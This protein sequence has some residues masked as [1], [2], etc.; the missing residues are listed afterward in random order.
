MV[1]EIPDLSENISLDVLCPHQTR[2]PLHFYSH[3]V[4]VI[5]YVRE[6]ILPIQKLLETVITVI[7]FSLDY[8]LMISCTK[9]MVIVTGSLPHIYVT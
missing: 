9:L 8:T 1:N 7:K 4:T 3:L 2:V 6:G 5:R